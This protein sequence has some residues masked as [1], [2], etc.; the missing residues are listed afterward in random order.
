[1]C[2]ITGGVW[3]DATQS[4]D[5]AS[6]GRMV[7]VLAHR[8]PDGTGLWT[9]HDRRVGLA[10][11]RLAIV[12]L[13][14]SANQPM[15]NEDGSVRIVFNGEIYNHGDVR[16]E[17][18]AA[19]HHYR[20]RSDTETIVHAYEQWGDDGV[21]RLRGMFA[22]AIW[23]ANRKTLFAARDRLGIKPFYYYSSPQGLVFGSEIKALLEH[24]DVR[25]ELDHQAL[26]AY[27]SLLYVPAPYTIWKNLR[28][29]PA[30]HT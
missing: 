3:A 30:A 23:D 13:S 7:D 9:S 1:M 8:G 19:G 20:T 17:L 18:E 4:I 28:K 15:E 6:V 12:D 21:H 29:L 2:G 24:P 11:R 22:F 25:R 27:L 10:F 26:D 5:E 16:P 14:P